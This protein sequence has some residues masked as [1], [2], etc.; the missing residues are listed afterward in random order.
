MRTSSRE[1]YISPTRGAQGNAIQTILAMGFV[2]DG[3][4]GET[5]IESQGVAHRIV[6][7]AD[8]VR[9]TPRIVHD[10]NASAVKNGVKT[11]VRWPNRASSILTGAHDDFSNV[12]QTFAWLN[13]HLTLTATWFGEPCVA[14]TASN[15]TWTKWLPSQPT[16]PHWYDAPRLA[17]LIAAHIAYAEDHEIPCP[18]VREFVAEFRGLSSTAKGKA[19]CEAVEASGRTLAEFYGERREPERVAALLKAM[20]ALSRP[21]KPRDLGVIGRDHLARFVATAGGDPDSFAYHLEE[22]TV[23][24]VPYL[25][26][27]AFAHAPGAARRTLVTGLNFSPAI[28]GN[29]FHSLGPVQSLDAAVWPVGGARRAGHR[30][31]PSDRAAPRFSRPGQVCGRPAAQGVGVSLA[32]LI[33]KA[34]AKW[35]KQR[36]AEIRDRSAALRRK[37]ALRQRYRS[38]TL[39]D[40]A[41]VVMEQAYLKASAN[42]TLPANAR[43]IYYAARGPILKATGRESLDSNYFT[44]SLLTDYVENHPGR[45]S[46]WNIVFDDRG[47]FVEPHTRHAFDSAP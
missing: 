32:N 39:K 8:P 11:T 36:T 12:A 35:K 33:L 7:G 6:F 13:P 29:P 14:V 4:R 17:R 28:G 19:I 44:Q 37:E 26:E 34:T 25:A 3:E 45:T 23:G 15:P 20:Q 5:A 10:R 18:T 9:R 41:A 16:S 2:L 27:V 31:R 22:Q 24:G 47:H 43:Q 1:A 40:A 46:G 42:G 30:L 38:L 21:V